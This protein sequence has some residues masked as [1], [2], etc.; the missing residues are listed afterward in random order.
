MPG[1]Q[2]ST[3]SRRSNR[4]GRSNRGAL[5]RDA[6]RDTLRDA[7]RDDRNQRPR[8]DDYRRRDDHY[9][10]DRRHDDRHRDS[11]LDRLPPGK[12]F[13]Q[14][15][16]IMAGVTAVAVALV[17]WYLQPPFVLADATIVKNGVP[18]A[19]PAPSTDWSRIA[20]GGAFAGMAVLAWDYFAPAQ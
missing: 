18:T 1:S 14:N 19:N 20:M 8:Y 15:V 11:T 3:G 9:H 12:G 17:L 13:M 7:P 16:K 6:A 2:R 5:P 4:S 10:D